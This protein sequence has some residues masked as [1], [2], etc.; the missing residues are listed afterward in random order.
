MVWVI[1]DFCFLF[2]RI[3]NLPL[4]KKNYVWNT[5]GFDYL[6]MKFDIILVTVTLFIINE[7]S[8]AR[9]ASKQFTRYDHIFNFVS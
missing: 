5:R 6:G 9:D 3:R 7:S 4:R 8:G 2:F 1:S